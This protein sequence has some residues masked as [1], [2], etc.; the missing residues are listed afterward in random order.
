MIV[1][2]TRITDGISHNVQRTGIKGG[3]SSRSS[4]GEAAA[5]R[6]KAPKRKKGSKLHG[7]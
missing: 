3:K 5:K 6:P 4:Y 2:P 1:K 7:P